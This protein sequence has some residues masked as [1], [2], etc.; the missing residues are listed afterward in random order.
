M[1]ILARRIET[2][3]L[4]CGREE[5]KENYCARPNELVGAGPKRGNQTVVLARGDEGNRARRTEVEKDIW[6][7]GA[8]EIN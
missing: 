7:G 5:R 2:R 4:L 1:V 8:K 6:C 3:E